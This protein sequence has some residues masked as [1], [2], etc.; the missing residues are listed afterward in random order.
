VRKPPGAPAAPPPP[1]RALPPTDST[2]TAMPPPGHVT[3][4]VPSSR[5]FTVGGGWCW[6]ELVTA[7]ATAALALSRG[8]RPAGLS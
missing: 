7:A 1:P 8:P 2:D 6:E 5:T 3:Y 4:P